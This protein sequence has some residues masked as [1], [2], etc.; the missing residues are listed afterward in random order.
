MPYTDRSERIRRYAPHALGTC[1]RLPPLSEACAPQKRRTALEQVAKPNAKK[2]YIITIFILF[3]CLITSGQNLVPNNG[4]EINTGL[5][6]GAAQW[7]LITGWTNAGGTGSPDYFHTSGTGDAQLPNSYFG[8]VNPYAGDAIMGFIF[9]HSSST[10]SREYIAIQLSNP[11]Q[12]GI[13]YEVSFYLTCGVNNGNYGGYGTDQI[14]ILFTSGSVT[15]VGSSTIS[16]TPQLTN[17]TIFYDNNWQKISFQYTATAAYDYITIG[18]FQDDAGTN[19]QF[20]ESNSFSAVYYFIDEVFISNT[21][22]LQILGNT[23]ICLGDSITLTAVNDTI[24]GRADSLNPSIIIGNDSL[25]W[26]APTTTTTYLVYGS[27]D[28]A[29]FT[30]NVFYPPN[31]DFGND[32]TLCQ[33]ETLTLDATT[34]NATYLWQD[35]STNPTFN[36]SQQGSY[37]VEVSVS[38]CSMAD[39]IAVSYNTLPTV[40]LG[41]DTTLCQ[42][43]T[44][45]LGATTANATYLWQDSSTNPIFIITQQG[46]YRVEVINICGTVSETV[47]IELD[48]CDCY[49]CIP[50]AFT[51][52]GNGIDVNNK[53]Y[54][55]NKLGYK[56]DALAMINFKIFN[57]W[58]EIIFEASEVSQIVYPDGGWDGTHMGSG[59][60]LEVGV[61]V[62]LMEAQAIKTG[63]I[64]PVSGNVSLIR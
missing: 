33:G 1:G 28:T 50:D 9:W 24:F 16:A 25:L 43:E 48:D 20:Y 51:P 6:S 19:V 52:N 14:S 37:W 17:G 49:L 7:S 45:T 38:N 36:V 27:N 53:L 4:F 23:S 59:K 64:G 10:N 61:Y 40:D 39:T 26:V 8:T 56:G 22:T 54:I 15:Q 5:P 32:T 2:K 3:I 44:F 11:M 62:W 57:R 60:K 30:V 55:F 12:I 34:S 21:N 46:T 29:S 47:V 58:G 42:G 41:N 18:N 13:V 35:S 63:K 31:V